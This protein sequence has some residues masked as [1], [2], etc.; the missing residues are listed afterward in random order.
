MISTFKFFHVAGF[1]QESTALP[2]DGLLLF[3]LVSL[4]FRHSFE[5]V[6]L[7]MVT[8]YNQEKNS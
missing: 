2:G 7:G 5:A 8:L 1:P 4:V 3:M 6:V